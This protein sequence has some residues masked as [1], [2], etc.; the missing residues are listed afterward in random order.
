MTQFK[1]LGLIGCG[2]MGGSFAMA[3]KKAGIVERVVGYSKSPH[4]TER[5]KQLGVVDAVAGSILQAAMGSDLVLIS[6][7]VAA[8]FEVFK[9]LHFGLAPDTLVMDVGSTKQSVM[10]AVAKACGGLPA[11]FVPAH[12]IAGKEQAGIA[13]A[14]ALLYKGKQVIL[15]PHADFITS[16]GEEAA[17]AQTYIQLA[18]A[19]WQ[20]LG[21]NVSI[22]PADK[23]DAIFAAVSHVPHLLSFAFINGLQMQEANPEYWKMAG[24]GFRDFTRIAASDPDVWRDILIANRKEILKQTGM[25]QL[26]LSQ[27]EYAMRA[28]DPA[29]LKALIEPASQARAAWAMKH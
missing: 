26:A 20:A 7:P 14:D 12:P 3:A 23:H 9:A 28:G 11:N 17:R 2:L 19:V 21:M 29:A 15:T 22:M 18:K 16:K 27:L 25:L 5:A 8:T 24:S 6:V 13:A 1:Q 10:D 4:S